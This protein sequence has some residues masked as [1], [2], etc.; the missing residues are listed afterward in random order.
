M[1]RRFSIIAIVLTGMVIQGGCGTIE[2]FSGPKEDSR[3]FVG[4]RVDVEHIAGVR[5][6][7]SSCNDFST[8]FLPFHILDLPFSLVVDTVFLPFLL[9][10]ELCCPAHHPE[11]PDEVP[12]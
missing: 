7:A 3:I 1:I 9:V 2:G 11:K 10:S 12:K 5:H 6:D 8:I 4:V